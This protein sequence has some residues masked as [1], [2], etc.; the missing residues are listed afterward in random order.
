VTQLSYQLVNAHVTV[1]YS[2]NLT[3]LYNILTFASTLYHLDIFFGNVPVFHKDQIT[4]A[5]PTDTKLLILVENLNTQSTIT[6]N[7]IFLGS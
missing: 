2:T 3:N 6:E 7:M 4:V 1:R 5:I